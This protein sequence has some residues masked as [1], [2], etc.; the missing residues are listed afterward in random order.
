MGPLPGNWVAAHIAIALKLSNGVLDYII[1]LIY[2]KMPTIVGQIGQKKDNSMT[3]IIIMTMVMTV[4]PSLESY[5]LYILNKFLLTPAFK[6]LLAKCRY[7]NRSK[8][9]DFL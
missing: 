7:N 9:L 5:L 8:R 3:F 6:K 1:L 4:L 2:F